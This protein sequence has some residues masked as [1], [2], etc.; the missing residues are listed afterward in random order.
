MHKEIL[1]NTKNCPQLKN[2]YLLTN[3][4]SINEKISPTLTHHHIQNS[5]DIPKIL[6]SSTEKK[7]KTKLYRA[8]II[9]WHQNFL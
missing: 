1:N 5:K 3:K 8:M 6:K 7:K 9:R 2:K 4:Q